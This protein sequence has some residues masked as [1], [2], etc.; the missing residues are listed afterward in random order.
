MQKHLKKLQMN[1]DSEVVVK[2]EHLLLFIKHKFMFFGFI[3]LIN[4]RN[5][6]GNISM[7]S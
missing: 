1:S 6:S 4:R 5:L 7:N 2:D 3:I